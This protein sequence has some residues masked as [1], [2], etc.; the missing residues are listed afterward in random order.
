[1]E[2]ECKVLL[3]KIHRKIRKLYQNVFIFMRASPIVEAIP[4]ENSREN[5][6]TE[7]QLMLTSKKSKDAVEENDPRK[8]K[9]KDSKKVSMINPPKKDFIM[10]NLGFSFLMSGSFKKSILEKLSHLQI[11]V[12]FEVMTRRNLIETLKKVYYSTIFHNFFHFYFKK[13]AF[14]IKFIRISSNLIF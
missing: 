14:L 1:L 12:K 4:K 10:K 8:F 6:I 9:R 3:D 11:T 13:E 2:S 7:S 5:I